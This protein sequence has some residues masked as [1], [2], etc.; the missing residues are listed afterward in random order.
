MRYVPDAGGLVWAAVQLTG[1]H[2]PIGGDDPALAASCLPV[3][4]R[5]WIAGHRFPGGRLDPD[6]FL[7]ASSAFRHG[8]SFLSA[9]VFYLSA[10]LFSKIVVRGKILDLSGFTGCFVTALLI[11]KN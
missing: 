5:L 7:A 3:G 4:H 9:G 11:L 8:A 1:D 6:D 2:L 10:L